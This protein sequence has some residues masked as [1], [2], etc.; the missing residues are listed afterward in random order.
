MDLLST[1]YLVCDHIEGLVREAA[2]ARLARGARAIEDVRPAA[3]RRTLGRGVRG[4]SFV[5]GAASSRLDPG[6]DRGQEAR[7]RPLRA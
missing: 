3:W 5:L 4:L 2:T 6:L 7:R 1:Q